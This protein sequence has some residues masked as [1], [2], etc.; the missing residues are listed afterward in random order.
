MY[1]LKHKVQFV[2]LYARVLQVFV[3]IICDIVLERKLCLLNILVN[4]AICANIKKFRKMCAN[5]YKTLANFAKCLQFY[6]C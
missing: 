1:K 6:A 4:F 3:Q 5:V 2:K